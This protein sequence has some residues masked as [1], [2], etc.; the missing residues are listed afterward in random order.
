MKGTHYR[1]RS[2]CGAM[3]PV[4]EH[5]IVVFLSLG[6]RVIVGRPL[7]VNESQENRWETGRKDVLH[8]IGKR[9]VDI[10]LLKI[11]PDNECKDV[12]SVAPIL[13]LEGQSHGFTIMGR[14][15]AYGKKVTKAP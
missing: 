1:V 14:H 10:K 5:R 6:K 4:Q 13:F 15:M 12:V 7:Q 9:A 3:H 2:T 8:V 11:I